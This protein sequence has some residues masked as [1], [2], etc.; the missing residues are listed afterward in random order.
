MAVSFWPL[1]CSLDLAT[2]SWH[3]LCKRRSKRI[4][5][6]VRCEKIAS[7]I[8]IKPTLAHQEH[9]TFETRSIPSLKFHPNPVKINQLDSVF[10][11]VLSLRE[12]SNHVCF[13]LCKPRS[14]H[15]RCLRCRR[16]LATS[17]GVGNPSLAERCR[18]S[19]SHGHGDWGRTVVLALSLGKPSG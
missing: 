9:Q 10:S 14:S 17:A 6:V 3:S 5:S 7:A 19:C 18:A 1:R 4:P 11:G 16:F 15:L 12:S 13:E 2:K 8:L